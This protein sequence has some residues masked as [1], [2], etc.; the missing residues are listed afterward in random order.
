MNDMIVKL[1]HISIPAFTMI[2]DCNL[3]YLE[4]DG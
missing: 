3:I 2:T 4:N 1:Y